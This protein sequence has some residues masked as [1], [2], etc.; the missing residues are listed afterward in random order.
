MATSQ[1]KRIRALRHWKQRFDPKARFVWRKDTDW[2]EQHFGA[3][4]VIPDE[5]I[6]E[7]GRAKL[8]RFWESHF[9]EL[10]EFDEPDVMTGIVPPST[11]V[12]VPIEP[13]ATV[14]IPVEGADGA[15]STDRELPDG[16]TVENSG[17][18]W[19]TVTIDGGEPE[20]VRG[21]DALEALLDGLE[22]AE[23]AED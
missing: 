7:M 9:I 1:P 11:E 17:G 5:I 18:G 15:S 21:H 19:Y 8:R 20:R 13:S 23:T 6:E 22:T 10:A 2:G 3:G 12:E 4:T 16:V 14:E